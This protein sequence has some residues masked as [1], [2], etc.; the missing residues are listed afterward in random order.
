[1]KTLFTTSNFAAYCILVL[2]VCTAACAR[3]RYLTQTPFGIGTT[4]ATQIFR[5]D[6][7]FINQIYCIDLTW[8]QIPTESQPG[9]FIVKLVRPNL[10]DQTSLP[11][12]LDSDQQ[13][14]VEL[15]MPS[16]GHGSSPVTVTSIDT[17]TYRVSDVFF[18]MRGL[19]EIHIDI[20]SQGKKLDSGHVN[21]SY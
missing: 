2:T 17:G 10:A 21:V 19:W 13:L 1:M 11:V 5:C 14:S 18:I 15:W 3:P 20:L 12:S 7:H 9:S 6:A 16:M 4:K 8:E